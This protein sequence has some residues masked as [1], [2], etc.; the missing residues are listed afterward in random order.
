[1]NFALS[2]PQHEEGMGLIED[3]E[4]NNNT[5][6]GVWITTGRNRLQISLMCDN[7]SHCS[8]VGHTAHAESNR[9]FE[10]FPVK[11]FMSFVSF[12]VKFCLGSTPTLR[13]NRIHSGKQVQ[14]IHFCI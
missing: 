4:I 12:F 1:M 9:M 5:L 10:K 14:F 2:L 7:C 11:S 8:V 3:N 13:H 6:A